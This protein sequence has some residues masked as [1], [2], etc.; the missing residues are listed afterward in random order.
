MPPIGT[1]LNKTTSENV[2]PKG[3]NHILI[4]DSA[5]AS[6]TNPMPKLINRVASLLEAPPSFFE[7]DA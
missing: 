2:Y 5:K 4:Y 1:R 3:N 6:I 7:S